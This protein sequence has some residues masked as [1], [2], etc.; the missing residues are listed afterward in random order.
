LLFPGPAG[1]LGVPFPDAVTA[2]VD[3]QASLANYPIRAEARTGSHPDGAYSAPGV[4][5]VAHADP[6]T[7]NTT[8]DLQG[9]EQPGTF[10]YGKTHTNSQSTLNGTT[11]RVTA[12]S[13]VS[14]IN[15]GGAVTI[16][17][18]T[19]TAI[20]QTNGKTSY[21]SGSTMVSN[22]TIG[23]QPAYVDGSGV[24]MGKPGQPSNPAADQVANQALSGFG[25]KIYTSQ[26]QLESKGPTTNYTAGSL[27][28]V[29]TPPGDSSHNVFTLSF[30]GARASVSGVVGS[31]FALPSTPTVTP[32][33]ATPT[34]GATSSAP[35]PA[36]VAT[37][38]PAAATPVSSS[39]PQAVPSPAP[40][41][42]SQLRPK[43]AGTFRGIGLGWAAMGL[44]GAGLLFAATRRLA[45]DLLDRP[46]GTCPL[47][48]T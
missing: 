26:P 1:N 46:L 29:W 39:A 37:P 12:G 27:I 28:F 5:L 9:A 32:P 30:G 16:G 25:M 47:E 35:L 18:V 33:A 21:G 45:I 15:V 22:M 34:P 11:G 38:S 2:L 10:S 19:S 43:L 48:R 24:H 13:V 42:V 31:P 44:A 7:V 14:N 41:P 40:A 4:N 17:S 6:A 8:A 20:A 36:T 23:G 3:S